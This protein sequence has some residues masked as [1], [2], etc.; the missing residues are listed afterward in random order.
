MALS[1]ED[2][3]PMS[4]AVDVGVSIGH[5]IWLL[6]PL[7]E[8]RPSQQ[9]NDV[10]AR[11]TPDQRALSEDVRCRRRCWGARA[12]CGPLVASPLATGAVGTPRPV[13]GG[14]PR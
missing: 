9:S 13:V 1:A 7:G 2:V 11:P 8:R 12:A 6:P 4:S 10:A 5:A 14:Y 3:M